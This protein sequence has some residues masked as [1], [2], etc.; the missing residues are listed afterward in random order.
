MSA[1]K[2]SRLLAMGAVAG[3]LASSA[4]VAAPGWAAPDV[5]VADAVPAPTGA[6]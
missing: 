4:Y 5:T 6:V 2:A 1:G 3:V